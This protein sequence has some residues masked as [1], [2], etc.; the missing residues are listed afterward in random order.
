M[1]LVIDTN[2][3]SYSND[4]LLDSITEQALDIPVPEFKEI[5]K[6]INKIVKSFIPKPANQIKNELNEID[7]KLATIYGLLPEELKYDDLLQCIDSC[8]AHLK[9]IQ[10]ELTLPTPKWNIGVNCI[11][12]SYTL[13]L[14]EFSK[15]VP[16][17]NEI[18]KD[19]ERALQNGSGELTSYVGGFACVMSNFYSLYAV[20]QYTTNI[21]SLSSWEQKPEDFN[22]LLDEE[23][24]CVINPAINSFLQRAQGRHVKGGF[25]FDYPSWCKNVFMQGLVN[26]SSLDGRNMK[27]SIEEM[28]GFVCLSK[29]YVKGEVCDTFKIKAG[30]FGNSKMMWLLL[31][32]DVNNEC[33]RASGL[34]MENMGVNTYYYLITN[35][36]EYFVIK[37]EGKNITFHPN[38]DFVGSEYSNLGAEPHKARK[39]I[40]QNKSYKWQLV[41]I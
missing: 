12:S 11:K 5:V 1:A 15:S 27:Y 10:V 3:T 22:N 8:L 36:S 32:V 26:I 7:E 37:Y 29:S 17:T 25:T 34:L 4:E 14:Y 31:N 6:P 19:Y 16:I 9:Q 21:L 18:L 13:M 41:N 33:K 20:I 39:V 38:P 23:Q 28:E 35:C 2:Q 40:L 24:N 30:R